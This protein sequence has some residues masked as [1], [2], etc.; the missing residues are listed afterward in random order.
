MSRKL[1]WILA[2]IAVA[3]SIFAP[4]VIYP[5]EA[6]PF[7]F[8]PPSIKGSRDF[9]HGAEVVHVDGALGPES[10]AFDPNGGGPYTGVGDGRILR[11][12]GRSIGWTD[13]AFT[14]PNR[15]NVTA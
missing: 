10:L 3:I 6:H 4:P 9:L 11:W 13:F 2:I 7:F 12:Q 8:S 5:Y 14:S 15:Y 1:V